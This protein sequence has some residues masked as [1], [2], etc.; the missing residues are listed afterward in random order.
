MTSLKNTL[1]YV[2]DNWSTIIVIIGLLL[3]LYVKVNTY[4]KTSKEEKISIAKKALSETILKKVSDAEID[5]ADYKKSGSI[6]RAQVLENIYK[7]YP[8][9][10]EVVEQEELVKWIDSLIDDGLKTIT[11]VI[12]D[13][14]VL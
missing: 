7:D 12:N 2:N 9:L 10:K 8:I 14:D 4:L 5:W 6:K 13:D 1:Q 3:G 11:S